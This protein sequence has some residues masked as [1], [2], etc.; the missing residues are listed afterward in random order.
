M[1]IDRCRLRA[2]ALP[3]RHVWQT[4]RGTIR[5]R[6]GWI[7]ELCTDNGLQG[8]GDCAPLP[9]AGTETQ[10]QAETWLTERLAQLKNLSPI[11]ALE[12]L[13]QPAGTP[14]ARHALE[15]ALLDLISQAENLSLREWLSPTAVDEI[16]V[17]GL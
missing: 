14:A 1:I 11:D 7:V 13:P 16:A 3:L 6:A 8:C 2:Y 5:Q 9:A 15:T 10:L 4:N 12:R 17:N